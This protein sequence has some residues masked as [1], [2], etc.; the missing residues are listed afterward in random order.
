[1]RADVLD[2]VVA[3]NPFRFST[4]YTDLETGLIYY[5]NR[6]YGSREGRFINRDPIQEQGGLNLY[7]FAGNNSVSHWDLLGLTTICYDE[8][9]NGVK[10]PVCVT[11]DPYIPQNATV[12]A[13]GSN[14]GIS[15]TGTQLVR[16]GSNAGLGTVSVGA[17]S[18]SATS[19]GGS[20]W[21]TQSDGTPIL[22]LDPYKLTLSRGASG[23]DWDVHDPAQAW[24]F[25]PQAAREY[26][27]PPIVAFG[28]FDRSHGGT[29]VTQGNGLK[30]IGAGVGTIAEGADISVKLGRDLT[31]FARLAA[32]D[33]EILEL[34][35]KRL[36]VAGL[37]LSLYGLGYDYETNHL[38]WRSFADP[39]VA[40]VSLIPFAPTQLAA[41]AYGL[42]AAYYDLTH[43]EKE[44]EGPDGP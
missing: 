43:L 31:T 35:S 5:G 7:G 25:Q 26:S 28:P 29:Y 37:I 20:H 3:D 11:D 14:Y 23:D 30:I 17:G 13:W 38:W 44:G 40:G 10:V 6:Y 8:I 27:G 4:K 12:L 21:E 32:K 22:V 33:R 36:G 16:G 34:A 18:T 42:G 24:R 15:S 41:G 2:S 39:I 1:M 19:S 9:I